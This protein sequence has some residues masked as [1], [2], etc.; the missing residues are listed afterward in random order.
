[1][2]RSKLYISNICDKIVMIF[3]SLTGF[4]NGTRLYI[5][6]L[7]GLINRTI[8]TTAVFLSCIHETVTNGAQTRDPVAPDQGVDS[9][10]S[11]TS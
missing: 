2:V 4:F 1:M 11:P 7:V 9:L 10:Q 5:S 6:A 3:L 8:Q